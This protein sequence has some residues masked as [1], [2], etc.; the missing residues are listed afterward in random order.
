MGLDATVFCDCVERGRLTVPHPY[1][2]LLYI[3]SNGSPEIRTKDPAKVE[4]H[5]QWIDL[6]PCKHEQ[7]RVDGCDLG[8]AWFITDLYGILSSGLNRLSAVHSH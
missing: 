5:D 1:P 8:N 6:P 7:M 3:A 4:K 2:G